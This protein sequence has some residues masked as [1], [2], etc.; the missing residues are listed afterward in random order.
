[1]IQF[2]INMP[3]LPQ[4]TGLEINYFILMAVIA[5]ILPPFALTAT[6]PAFRSLDKLMATIAATTTTTATTTAAAATTTTAPAKNQKQGATFYLFSFIYLQFIYY[7]KKGFTSGFVGIGGLPELQQWRGA[8]AAA[9]AAA[10]AASLP[11][12]LKFVA[13]LWDI[14]TFPMF[15]LSPKLATASS[16]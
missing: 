7:I 5:H 8:V 13:P 2:T 4:S 16:S 3:H 10:A 6:L 15:P 12:K 11:L 1:M 9:A 14:S